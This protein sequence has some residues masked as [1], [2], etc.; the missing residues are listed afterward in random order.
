MRVVVERT[1]SRMVKPKRFFRV[2]M[3]QR[4][5]V[6]VYIHGC[7][8]VGNGNRSARLIVIEQPCVG[9]FGTW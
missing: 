8:D 1:V 5:E 9:R 6:E 3:E 7:D 4:G 2:A